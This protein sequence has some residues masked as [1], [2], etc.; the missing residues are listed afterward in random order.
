LNDFET[1]KSIAPKEPAVFIGCG[2]MLLKLNK[3]TLALKAFT[4]AHDLDPQN[5][6]VLEILDKY[7]S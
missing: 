5:P 3:P 2:E 7:Q 6:K 1:L 4:T